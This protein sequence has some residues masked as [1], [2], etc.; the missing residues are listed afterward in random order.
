MSVYA[1][2][3]AGNNASCTFEL[4]ILPAADPFAASASSSSS[5]TTFAAAGGG[6]GVLIVLV[7]VVIFFVLARKRHQKV[8]H[9]LLTFDR[10]PTPPPPP[11]FSS[12]FKVHIFLT[13]ISAPCGRRVGLCRSDG[14]VGR[15]YSRARQGA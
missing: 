14:H 4:R 11:F 2:D 10:T 8:S 9:A 13:Q 5:V 6:G 15:V 3:A 12:S 1:R 7:I